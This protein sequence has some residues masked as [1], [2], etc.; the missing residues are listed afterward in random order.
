[1]AAAGMAGLTSLHFVVNPHMLAGPFDPGAPRGR[2]TCKIGWLSEWLRARFGLAAQRQMI[3][4]RGSSGGRQGLTTI[5]EPLPG[6]RV[7]GGNTALRRR[8]I[9]EWFCVSVSTATPSG[10]CSRGWFAPERFRFPRR[11]DCGSYAV[12]A[13]PYSTCRANLGH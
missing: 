13:T 10:D 11:S 2:A 12:T 9:V 6:G 1:M 7:K 4:I 8:F 3:Q 5:V